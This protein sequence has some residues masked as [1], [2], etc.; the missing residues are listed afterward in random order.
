M[1]ISYK[2]LSE[3]LPVQIEPEKLSSILTSIG[4]EVESLEQF[5]SVKGG[6]EG[7]V[8]GK[9]VEVAQHPNADKL[10]L[11]KVNIGT[12]TPLNIVCGADN[13]AAG[14]TVLVATIGTTI[15]PT[16]GEPMTM[17]A[18]KIRGEE[19]HGMIC[20]E[21]ELGLGSSH[22]GIMVLPNDIV[23]GTKAGDYFNT[24][25]DWIYEIGLTPN[26]MDAMSHLGVAKDV[27]A[28][29][30]HHENN[31][32]R[33]INPLNV[34]FKSDNNQLPIK[35]EIEDAALC[36]RYAGVSISGIV[37]KES[38]EW[39]KDKLKAIGQKPINNIVDITN[40][41]LHETG[42]PLHAFDADAIDNQTVI[43]RN[44]KA[45]EVFVTLDDKE[46]KLDEADLLICNTYEAMCIAGVFGGAKSGI[47]N[48]TTNIFLESAW[49][50]PGSIRKTSFRHGLRTEA[51]TRFEKGVDISNVVNVLKRA[52]LLIKEI[53]G[54]EIS[55]DIVDIYPNPENKTE[56]TLKYHYLK[57]L[58]GKNY[59]PDTVKRILSTLSF[60]V[61]NEGIDEIRI[62][63]PFS[64]PDI[65][66]PADVVE[67]ILRIDGLDNIDI[68]CAFMLTPSV[69]TNILKEN[70]KEKIAGYLIGLGFSEIVTN[71]ITN[72]R[73]YKQDEL[74]SS[75]KMIN[76][77]SADLDV[78]R[79]SMIESGLETIAYNINRKNKDLLLFEFGK[80]YHSTEIGKYSEKE[81]LTL[82]ITGNVRSTSWK[83]KEIKSDFY[84]GKGIA[85]A[86]IRLCGLSQPV[87]SHHSDTNSSRIEGTVA[88]NNL[89]SVT[90][91]S[92]EKLQLFDIKQPVYV[93]DI[94][95]NILLQLS[96]K[97]KITYKEVSKFPSVQRDLSIVVDKHITY[98]MAENVVKKVKLNT[99]QEMQLFDIFESEK[100]GKDKKSMAVSFLFL[101]ENKTLTDKETDEM[102]GKLI[103]GFETELSAEI[104][105]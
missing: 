76:S 69:D 61:V 4:L 40:Y 99:L 92:G 14:Q 62:A 57:K 86:I 15:Y 63:V 56:V 85:D 23:A 30:S 97:Q 48:N 93:V 72:S 77:L 32:A 20:A 41:I 16:G 27:C 19:S 74:E 91:I 66:L 90:D 49:F 35:V 59:H 50:N 80:T 21:D 6:L 25:S 47:K 104:R 31:D 33:P 70:L 89:I 8:V 78:M 60:E 2:W 42:Q 44:A 37:V 24:Y 73:Y 88:K 98:E 58:S 7:V 36:K 68:T 100:L 5:Q 54:G 3:Y 46:R 94:D 102:M 1:T 34:N 65:T 18:A 83:A 71:S 17:K 28:Y 38:P 67:E 39:L 75:V 51:A 64:K 26:R 9:V 52:S 84:F 43:I 55:S 53:A 81:H 101:D 12:D 82:Y 103:Q 10:K 79:P 96:T 11:T 22:E 13:V 105:K 87:Y 29:I 95:W 45:G